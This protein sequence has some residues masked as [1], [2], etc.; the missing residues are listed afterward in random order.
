[1]LQSKEATMSQV[2]FFALGGLGEDGKNM[3]VFSVDGRLFIFDAG[4]KYPEQDLLGVEAILPSYQYLI[5]HQS[6]IE[7]FFLSHGHE[8]HIGAMPKILNEIKAPI[9]GSFFTLALLK[10]SL[11]HHKID[12]S[13]LTFNTVTKN[14]VIDFKSAKVRFYQTTHSIPGSLGIALDTAD[15]MFVYSPDYTFDQNVDPIYQTSF[16]K[17]H[18][19]TKKPVI[20]L[21]SESLG[22]I[23]KSTESVDEALEFH[24]NQGF[25]NRE[26][27]IIVS[28]FSTDIYR[29]QRV[30]NIALKYERKIA[31]I[32]R[33]AQRMID[34]AINT[35]L[36]KIPADQ[37]KTLKFIDAEKDAPKDDNVMILVAGDRHEPFHMI[38]RM[39][40]K[41][42]RLVHLT[43]N[44]LVLLMTPAVPGTEKIA[45]RMLD[46]LFRHNIDLQQID[47]AML[48][49]A[50][51]TSSDVKLLNNILKPKY[52]VPVIGEWRHFFEMRQIAKQLSY[53]EKEVLVCENGQVLTFDGGVLVKNDSFVSVGEILVDGSLEES[54]HD[55]VLKDR[56][57]L[58]QDGVLIIS[59]ALN[60]KKRTLLSHPEMNSRGFVYVKDNEAFLEE[61]A[62]IFIKV[63]EKALGQPQF[64]FKTTRDSAKDAIAK[65]IMQKT[66]RR[67]II[68]PMLV[69]VDDANYA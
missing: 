22:A 7:G 45:S 60:L 33:K 35:G 10:D 47:K 61:V 23:R 62:Q 50:H 51:A 4:I 39:A 34:I 59:G 48:P 42:D 13:K 65:F 29:I 46:I 1:M 19:L 57:I 66:S 44:D 27:R 12:E 8:D 68:M 41:Q 15:G 2:Q 5:D 54:I 14:S 67:P 52:F 31:I 43:Q 6:Q 55:V 64:D 56:E 37:F 17:I 69:S 25:M 11:K 32:G 24:I 38:Q 20:A 63:V 30:I 49:P 40:L 28:A 58:S 18:E 9:Y 26:K 53:A 3:Y 21:F 16:D 36:L